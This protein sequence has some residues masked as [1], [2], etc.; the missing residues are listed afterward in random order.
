MKIYVHGHYKQ[1]ELCEVCLHFLLFLHPRCVCVDWHHGRHF[2]P[3]CFCHNAICFIGKEGEVCQERKEKEKWEAELVRQWRWTSSNAQK[4]PFQKGSY[5]YF[6]LKKTFIWTLNGMYFPGIVWIF[7]VFFV[8]V[9]ML[10]RF[11]LNE[12]WFSKIWFLFLLYKTEYEANDIV[13]LI[14]EKGDENSR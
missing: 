11:N 4:V 12:Y 3:N 1:M 6:C 2:F 9:R 8:C 7:L 10:F 13:W 14:Q 5:I